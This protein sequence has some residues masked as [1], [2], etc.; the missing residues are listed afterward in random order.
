MANKEACPTKNSKYSS[1]EMCRKNGW[2]CGT[3]LIG[4]EG[5]GPTVIKITGIGEDEILAKT[6]SRNGKA[7]EEPELNWT[8]DC[9]DWREVSNG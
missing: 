1:A 3:L 2:G 6:I 7:I 5:Y 4:D 8:L 9:R